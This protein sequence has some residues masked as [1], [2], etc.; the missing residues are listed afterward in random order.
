[1]VFWFSKLYQF[2]CIETERE[3]ECV[4]VHVLSVCCPSSFPSSAVQSPTVPLFFH[5]LYTRGLA[6][7]YSLPPTPTHLFL[8]QLPKFVTEKEKEKKRKKPLHLRYSKIIVFVVLLSFCVILTWVRMT[9]WESE[10]VNDKSVKFQLMHYDYTSYL[11]TTHLD[12]PNYTC[13]FGG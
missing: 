4:C 10:C 13:A 11:L 5:L 3:R 1:M 2:K 8:H 6:L 7:F 9:Q 12:D